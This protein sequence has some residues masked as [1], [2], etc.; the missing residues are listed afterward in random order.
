MGED[1]YEWYMEQVYGDTSPFGHEPVDLLETIWDES[2]EW[3]GCY[4]VA[5]APTDE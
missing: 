5:P 4:R 3:P 1:E 2:G